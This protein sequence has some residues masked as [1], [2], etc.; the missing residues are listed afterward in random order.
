MPSGPACVVKMSCGAATTR[1]TSRAPQQVA[2][3][4]SC[5]RDAAS[6][7]RL[8][9]RGLR[10]IRTNVGIGCTAAQWSPSAEKITEPLTCAVAVTTHLVLELHLL[11]EAQDDARR[12]GPLH[13][14]ADKGGEAA[15][16]DLVRHLPR[17]READ[18]EGRRSESVRQKQFSVRACCSSP[19]YS[20]KSFFT[21]H[22]SQTRRSWLDHGAD[23]GASSGNR[24]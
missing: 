5:V 14:E 2:Q 1:H 21:L 8:H 4:G 9:S 17:I 15:L 20:L 22:I 3:R 12:H 16:A 11:C 23:F 18:K 10:P 19:S 13:L 6:Q 24:R 7:H